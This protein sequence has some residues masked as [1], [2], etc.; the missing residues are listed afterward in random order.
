MNKFLIALVA[1]CTSVNVTA[2]TNLTGVNIP[3]G[4]IQDPKTGMVATPKM[5]FGCS[6]E[7]Y[8]DYDLCVDVF[9]YRIPQSPTNVF[10][11]SNINPKFT[12]NNKNILIR[13]IFVRRNQ[14]DGMFYRSIRLY[15]VEA[16]QNFFVGMEG[17][18][19]TY[20]IKSTNDGGDNWTVA[21]QDVR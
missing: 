16:G 8:G 14:T 4:V 12:A 11:K 15:D 13:Y 17:N 10:M 9:F 18:K 6:D 3:G 2:A 21:K 20:M 7:I 1:L 19:D 5:T